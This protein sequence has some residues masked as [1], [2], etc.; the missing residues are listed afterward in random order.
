M[1]SRSD[2]GLENPWLAAAAGWWV[3]TLK[4]LQ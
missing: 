1:G 2:A 4:L 3:V